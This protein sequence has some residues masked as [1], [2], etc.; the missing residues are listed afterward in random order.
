M[1]LPPALA[2]LAVKNGVSLDRLGER[3]RAVLLAFAA[4]AFEVD[5]GYREAEVNRILSAWLDGPGE[6]LRTDHVELRRWLV[7]AGFIG[8][9]GYG[10]SYVRGQN[11]ADRAADLLGDAAPGE[12]QAGVAALRAA[13]RAERQARRE[14]FAGR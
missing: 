8:R 6:M 10:R 3:D 9:D 13:R 12:I 2:A 5:R 14:V 11:E 7:D 1:T 4:C